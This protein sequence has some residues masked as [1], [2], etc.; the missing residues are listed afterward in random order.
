[1]DH[2]LD[3]FAPPYMVDF[4]RP[5]AKVVCA[6]HRLMLSV[7][8]LSF[9]AR[10]RAHCLGAP[11]PAGRPLSHMRPVQS[12]DMENEI[13]PLGLLRV[14]YYVGRLVYDLQMLMQ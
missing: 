12:Y 14:A 7:F 2:T 9:A 3:V 11:L 8:I 1:M 5:V 10:A 6:S 4:C 13:Q